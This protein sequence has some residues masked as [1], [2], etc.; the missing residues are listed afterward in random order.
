[1]E[2]YRSRGK[3]KQR[4]VE[5]LGDIECAIAATANQPQLRAQL[6]EAIEKEA[7]K[8]AKQEN[9]SNEDRELNEL[10]LKLVSLLRE[11]DRIEQVKRDDAIA[12]I[13]EFCEHQEQGLWRK[14]STKHIPKAAWEIVNCDP[15]S[16]NKSFVRWS[17]LAQFRQWL[18][19]WR[20]S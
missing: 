19:R 15:V 14:K 6:I 5:Y 17:K 13:K 1:M 10:R 18:E 11:I 3:V 16:L 7:S 2:T 9:L 20:F 12:S 4:M 8:Q